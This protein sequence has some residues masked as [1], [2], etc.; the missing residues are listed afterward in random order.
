MR[1]MLFDHCVRHEKLS[2][3]ILLGQQIA[4]KYANICVDI[5]IKLAKDTPIQDIQQGY[6]D[7]WDS[8]GYSYQWDI[9]IKV[10][11]SKDIPTM[12]MNWR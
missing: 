3:Q 1:K 5:P 11:P 12:A 7:V 9:K 4:E 10:L 2:T 8:V 6:R